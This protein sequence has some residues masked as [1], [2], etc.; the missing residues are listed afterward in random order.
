MSKAN[1]VDAAYEK[2]NQFIQ[3]FKALANQENLDPEEAK[4]SMKEM[5]IRYEKLLDEVMLLTSVGDR[6]QRKIKA[7]NTLLKEQAEEIRQIN[8]SLNQKNEELQLTIDELTR[9]KSGRKATTIILLITICLFI[10]SEFAEYLFQ[11]I[12]HF[13]QQ[14]VVYTT[15]FKVFLCLTFKPI[16]SYLEDSF[17]KRAMKDRKKVTVAVGS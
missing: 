9:A 16:E 3:Q 14:A 6:L 7:A 2:E 5:Q 15:I 12:T 17:L 1:S 11:T 4:K 10:A 13:D 8:A